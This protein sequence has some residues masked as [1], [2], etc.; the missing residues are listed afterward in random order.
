MAPTFFAAR[1]GGSFAVW[2]FVARHAVADE[3]D[4]DET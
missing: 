2:F 1:V 3:S 4:D